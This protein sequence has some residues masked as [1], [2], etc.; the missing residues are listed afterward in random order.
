LGNALFY[1]GDYQSA[2]KILGGYL[3]RYP[4]DV[5]GLIDLAN[6]HLQLRE[7]GKARELCNTGLALRSAKAPLWNCLGQIAH[8]EGDNAQAWELFDKAYAEAPEYTDALFNRANMA[9]RLGRV[10][11]ALNDFAMCVRKDE[12]YEPALLNMGIIRLERGEVEPGKRDIERVL[13]LN[14]AHVEARH[15]LGRLCLAGKE[16]RAARDAF[17]ETLKRDEDHIPTLLALA[18]LHIQEAEHGD[19]GAVLKR[20]LSGSRLGEEETVACLT[21]LMEM[22]ETGQCVHYLQRTAD[23]ALTPEARKLLVVGLWKLGRTKDAI[24]QLETVLEAEGETAATLT[25]LGRM[26]VQSGAESL[27]E[28]RYQKALEMDPSTQGAAFEMARIHLARGEGD[29]AVYV[30]EA[31]L[32]ETPDDPD[33]LYNL[34]CVH[35]RNRNFD[36]S[37]YYLKLALD[38]GFRDLDKINADDDLQLIRQF[39][40]YSQLAGQTGLI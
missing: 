9:Y 12:N 20:L 19:A 34:A 26:L 8:L 1:A 29:Q 10:E 3:E 39:K 25:M 22:G 33:C 4:G 35:A 24:G 17:R 6:C 27:A 11:E 18:K 15:L 23:V 31:L 21:L 32:R 37:L 30:L 7:L 14:P 36:D 2:K 40:E 5:H 38:K 28:T 13:K 16:F